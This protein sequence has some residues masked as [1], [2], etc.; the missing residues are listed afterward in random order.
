MTTSKGSFISYSADIQH[1]DSGYFDWESSKVQ[2][3]DTWELLSISHGPLNT[4]GDTGGPFYLKKTGWKINAGNPANKVLWKGPWFPTGINGSFTAINGPVV[5]NSD[6]KLNALGTSAIGYSAPNNPAFSM[7]TFLGE[8]RE[9]APSAIGW[10][11]FKERAHIA[12]SAG[13]EYLNVNFGWLPLVSDLRKFAY[14][15]NHS[16][17]ILHAY[18][19]G[20]DKKIR[21]SH[22]YPSQS[23]TS[24]FSGSLF[25]PPD[26]NFFTAGSA[27]E[28]VTQ[29]SWFSGAFRYHVPTGNGVL[30]KFNRFRSDANKLLGVNLT[31]EVLWN[32]SPWSWAA[33]WFANTGDVMKN[34]SNLG[35]DGLVLQYGYMMN[36]YR[37]ET[38]FAANGAS[39]IKFFDVKRRVPATPYGFGVDLQGLTAKQT[40]ILVALGLSHT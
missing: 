7:A 32:L 4:R 35:T 18:H 26:C 39:S 9:G 5:E 3:T 36:H 15:V 1:R 38:H 11:T 2:M 24:Q 6:T 40:A 30:D 20:S 37:S 28:L 23:R 12:R 21:R 8:L 14:A 13:S 25:G 16:H 31:P 33:D 10:T 17:E 19:K 27:M 29:D 22:S 34:V